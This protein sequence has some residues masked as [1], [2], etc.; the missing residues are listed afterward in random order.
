M[1]N[2]YQGPI[3]VLLASDLA[4]HLEQKRDVAVVVSTDERFERI[5]KLFRDK[6][7]PMSLEYQKGRVLLLKGNL[8]SG[9]ESVEDGLIVITDRELLAEPREERNPSLLKAK[10][11]S[12]WISFSQEIM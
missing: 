3:E 10:C 12:R 6:D 9:F 2:V 7:L 8:E 5:T 1:P 11:C 4:G